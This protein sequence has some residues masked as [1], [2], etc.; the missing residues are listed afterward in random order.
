MIFLLNSTKK[1]IRKNKEISGKK[2]KI[3]FAYVFGLFITEEKYNDIDV[4]VYI[5]IDQID[6]PLFLSVEMEKAIKQLL[7][8]L[9]R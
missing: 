1:D 8:I 4:A 2:E 7:D 9:V 3:V 6:Y 5:K